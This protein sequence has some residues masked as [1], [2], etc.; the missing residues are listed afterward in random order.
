MML[1]GRHVDLLVHP[2]I[3]VRI[4]NP[5][6]RR[7]LART[8]ELV[9]R[10]AT[11]NHRMHNKLLVVDGEVAIFGGRNLADEY[12]GL[13]KQYDFR[14][15]DV[16]TVGPVVG[17]RARSFDAYWNSDSAFPATAFSVTA[18]KDKPHVL[19][20][21][22]HAIALAYV[23]FAYYLNTE[24]VVVAHAPVL[25]QQV[26]DALAPDFALDSSWRVEPGQH[27]GLLWMEQRPDG[28]HRS[29]FEPGGLIRKREDFIFTLLPIYNQ[30]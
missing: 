7:K 30:I 5:F 25:A 13:N 4:L 15:L 9:R 3:E 16:L 10:F 27:G 6:A 23:L 21:I 11:L 20:K 14:D 28:Q 19:A 26:V 24:V 2:N 17:R 22:S 1:D 29:S 12:F 18:T 8:L